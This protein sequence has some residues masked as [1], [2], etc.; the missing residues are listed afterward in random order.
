[1]KNIWTH[2]Q[3]DYE[4]E[5]TLFVQ[6]I[7]ILKSRHVKTSQK[8]W[9]TLNLSRKTC[10]PRFLSCCENHWFIENL[11]RSSRLQIFFKIAVLKNF[12]IF[13][14][15]IRLQPATLLKRDP[16]QVFFF[17]YWKNF[18][19]HS[20]YRTVLMAPSASCY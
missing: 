1:M 20:F 16:T 18:K 10:F 5:N 8:E 6:Q 7:V 2:A 3:K 12:A 15:L 11:F 14:I 4:C 19:N 17:E 13:N 9:R